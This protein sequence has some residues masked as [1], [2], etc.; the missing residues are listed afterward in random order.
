MHSFVLR[1]CPHL[2]FL[3]VLIFLGRFSKQGNFVGVSSVFSAVFL[4]FSRVALGFLL[5]SRG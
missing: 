1:T 4:C 3:G 2:P 5:Q